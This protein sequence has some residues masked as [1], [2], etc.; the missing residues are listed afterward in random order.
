MLCDDD[1]DAYDSYDSDNYYDDNG[2]DYDDIEGHND[3]KNSKQAMFIT[4]RVSWEYA[5]GAGER[6][7]KEQGSYPPFRTHGTDSPRCQN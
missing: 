1:D 3:D 4:Y 5:E 7:W 2:H 6:V